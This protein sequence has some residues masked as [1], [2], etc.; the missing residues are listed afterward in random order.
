MQPIM[1]SEKIGKNQKALTDAGF[2]T[3]GVD[4]FYGAD[5]AKAVE[6]FQSAKNQLQM[7]RLA[8]KPQRRQVLVYILIK[9]E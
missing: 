8:S 4:K 5:T 2:D 6:T 9:I 1:V 7:V 3:K